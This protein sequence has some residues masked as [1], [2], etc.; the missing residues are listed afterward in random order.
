MAK[1]PT[2]TVAL[3]LRIREDLRR[4]LQREADKED[5]SLNGE[6]TRRLGN[7]FQADEHRMLITAIVGSPLF[8][9]DTAM[10]RLVYA[11]RNAEAH[12]VNEVWK[13][14]GFDP[15]HHRNRE[16]ALADAINKVIRVYFRLL[17]GSESDFPHRDNK[18]SADYLAWQALKL[19]RLQSTRMKLPVHDPEDMA[20]PELEEP[21]DESKSSESVSAQS[22]EGKS[23]D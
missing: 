5:V 16:P 14:N 18:E 7:S 6:I 20:W 4:K 17:D 9:H 22:T 11:V 13:K 8:P 1:K 12:R 15:S 23:D 3:T 10:L 19:A 2:D 21:T